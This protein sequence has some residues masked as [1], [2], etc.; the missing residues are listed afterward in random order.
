[1]APAL[2]GTTGAHLRARRAAQS[3]FD[4][5][6]L[7]QSLRC[8]Q[9]LH[10]GSPW[11]T[12]HHET[13]GKHTRYP[14]CNDSKARTPCGDSALLRRPQKLKLLS[15]ISRSCGGGARPDESADVANIVKMTS[16]AALS[17]IW[18]G[19]HFA[20]RCSAAG[21]IISGYKLGVVW[22]GS[23]LDWSSVA[24]EREVC[25]SRLQAIS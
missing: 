25:L 11:K 6:A 23:E 15:G 17:P 3:P 8:A 2:L 12:E 1:V 22:D 24:A 5:R 7:R 13:F 20:P 16:G 18:A 21:I 19:G 10:F 4:V 9:G 14:K